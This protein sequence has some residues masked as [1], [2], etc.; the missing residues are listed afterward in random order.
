MSRRWRTSS[1]LDGEA[2]FTLIEVI[3]ALVLTGLLVA[4]GTE[5]VR[6]AV[7]ATNRTLSAARFDS[8]ELLF[9]GVIRHA[10][11]GFPPAF[12]RR[13]PRL[14]REG[15]TFLIDDP[16]MD[17][18]YR[19]RLR[20]SAGNGLLVS[21]GGTTA[22]IPNVTE[23]A[24]TEIENGRGAVTGFRFELSAGKRSASFITGYGGLRL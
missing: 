17:R 20:L 5:G 16:K 14:T 3:V 13:P 10:L 23:I 1:S 12:W 18:G 21:Y 2:G 22:L 24:V 9:D 15:N 6:I 11:T 8:T 4:V 7:R 19:V